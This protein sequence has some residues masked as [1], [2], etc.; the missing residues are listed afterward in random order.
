MR[1]K[2]EI[3]EQ[4]KRILQW[5]QDDRKHLKDLKELQTPYNPNKKAIEINK[6]RKAIE[7]GKKVE[8]EKV[9]IY[10]EQP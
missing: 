1:E 9:P 5:T 10:E 7:S 6:S 4:K 8:E 2:R 3:E